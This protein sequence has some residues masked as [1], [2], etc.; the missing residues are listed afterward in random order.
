MSIQLI[1]IA[2]ETGGLSTASQ[3]TEAAVRAVEGAHL[4]SS[5]ELE[6]DVF[7]AEFRDE[8]PQLPLTEQEAL[9]LKDEHGDVSVVVSID[10]TELS[11]DGHGD[12][13]D[14]LHTKAFS[15]G[16]PA[17]SVATVVA[18]DAHDV[19]VRYSTNIDEALALDEG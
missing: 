10:Q 3:N 2:V 5:Q 16:H 19:L 7:D 4:I 8:D 11:G 13:L 15:F 12:I 17:A 6:V 9:A 14:L 18:A 1:T